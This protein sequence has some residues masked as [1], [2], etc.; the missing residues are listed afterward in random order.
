MHTTIKEIPIGLSDTEVL[1]ILRNEK[2]GSD[3]IQKVKELTN[4]PDQ[5]LSKWLEISVRTFRTYKGPSLELKENIKEKVILLI[6]LF[7]HGEDVFG[8]SD[9][10][11]KWLS[12]ENFFLDGSKPIN[13]INTISGIRFIDDRLTAMEYGD[14]I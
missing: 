12:T 4:L 2:I 13:L 10:F 7:K 8:N 6:S 1:Q 3:H 11:N 5:I 9:N 14:N